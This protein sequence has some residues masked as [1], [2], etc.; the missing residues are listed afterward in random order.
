MLLSRV[1]TVCNFTKN[2]PSHSTQSLLRMFTAPRHSPATHVMF[3]E[4]TETSHGHVVQVPIT[5]PFQPSAA[6][7]ECT[8]LKHEEPEIYTLS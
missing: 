1:T 5:F 7:S 3:L 8:G 2:P 6:L 4:A